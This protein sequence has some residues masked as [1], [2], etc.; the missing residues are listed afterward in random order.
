MDG[1]VCLQTPDGLGAV[2]PLASLCEADRNRVEKEPAGAS[3]ATE[4]PLTQETPAS[5]PEVVVE[6][7]VEVVASTPPA[8]APGDYSQQKVVVPFDFVSK[9]DEG[10]YG[11]KIGDMLVKKIRDQRTFAV[12]DAIDIRN[13]CAQHGVKIT[14]D[15]PLPEIRRVLRDLFDAQIAVWGSCERAA[16]QEW[17]IYDLTIKCADFSESLEPKIL[18]DKSAR[19]NSVSEI[20]HLYVAEMLDKLHGRQPGGPPPLDPLAEQNWA[21]NPNLVDNGSLEVADRGVPKGWED[22]G[23]QERQP[24]GNLVRWIA[25][26]NNPANHVI[27]FTFD[28]SVGDGFGVMYYSKPFPVQEGAK[29]RFQCRYRTNGPSVKVFVKCYDE[30]GSQYKP[31]GQTAAPSDHLSQRG[32]PDYVPQFGYLRECYRS[33]QNLKGPKNQWNTQTQDFTPKHTKYSPRWGR[34]MLYA[35]LGAGVVEFDDVV[36][37]QIVPASASD[38]KK[39]ARHS[40]DSSV[41]IKEM[42]ENERS[43][44]ESRQNHQKK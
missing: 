38:A 37:K 5:E 28:A 41:T 43:A 1:N 36:V 23:G 26:S 39:E 27:R 24:L 4:K 16:G 10:T 20:P 14:P 44:R 19:T 2:V 12:P 17:E 25:D 22:R 34:V 40:Q 7:M 13:L 35:Y 30:M 9:F 31:A 8:Q 3:T 42:E 21:D 33:Q 11:A 29:Y 15:T 18:Y 6:Q 32:E